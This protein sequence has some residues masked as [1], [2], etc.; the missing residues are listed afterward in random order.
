[1]V[2]GYIF[3]EVHSEWLMYGG[4]FVFQNRLGLYLEE[5]LRLKIDWVNL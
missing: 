2:Y 4:K 5:N 3:G 1:M